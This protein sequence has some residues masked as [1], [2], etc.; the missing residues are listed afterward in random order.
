MYSY[1]ILSFFFIYQPYSKRFAANKNLQL[2][3]CPTPAASQGVHTVVQTRDQ[4]YQRKDQ[5]VSHEKYS[6]NKLASFK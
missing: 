4:K 3:V 5:T 6:K 2:S 1:T